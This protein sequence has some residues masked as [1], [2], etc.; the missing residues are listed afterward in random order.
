MITPS[1]WLRKEIF[2]V[3]KRRRRRMPLL[4]KPISYI[5]SQLLKL[6]AQLIGVLATGGPPLPGG[7]IEASKKSPGIPRPSGVEQ[8]MVPGAQLV[9]QF[10]IAQFDRPLFDVQT[11]LWI[12]ERQFIHASEQP[13]ERDPVVSGKIA[14]E[15]G[16]L[17][18]IGELAHGIA[19]FLAHHPL[20]VELG[21]HVLQSPQTCL[22]PVDL[23]AFGI[24]LATVFGDETDTDQINGVRSRDELGVDPIFHVL[25]LLALIRANP[26]RSGSSPA[27]Y[28][29]S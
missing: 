7:G 4:L 13:I 27:V 18:P 8:R 14:P 26:H 20:A 10:R 21:A 17:V 2:R 23:V 9:R 3:R 6:R 16:M 25:T 28:E 11:K 1:M 29:P 15:H 12:V 24:E 5:S 19:D 22:R